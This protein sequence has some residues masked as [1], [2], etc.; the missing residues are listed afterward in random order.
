MNYL[1]QLTLQEREKLVCFGAGDFGQK[2][3]KICQEKGITISYFCDNNPKKWG[4]NLCGV[5]ICSL[6]EI[7]EK[8]EKWVFVL[9]NQKYQDEIEL[10]LEKKGIQEIY[11][12]WWEEEWL[13]TGKFRAWSFL[14]FC[15]NKTKNKI[16]KKNPTGVYLK[17]ANI[18]VTQA[19]T[20]NCKYCAAKVPYLE[21]YDSLSYENFKEQIDLFENFFDSVA[22]IR[23][24]GGEPTLHPKLYEMIQ[25]ASSKNSIGTVITYTNGT[26]LFK[27]EELSKLNNQKIGFSFTDYSVPSAKIDENILILEKYKIGYE[28]RKHDI[29]FDPMA[30]ILEKQEN[31]DDI[32][33]RFAMCIAAGCSSIRDGHFQICGKP[34]QAYQNKSIPM[35]EIDW[36][37]LDV[38]EKSVKQVKC[39][40]RNYLNKKYINTCKYCPGWDATRIQSVPVG[41]QQKGKLSYPPGKKLKHPTLY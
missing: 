35:Q 40:L 6:E 12:S 27:E 33:E 4:T 23:F 16:S 14:N 41:E 19:C 25:Y 20:L 15:G 30:S 26:N 7:L 39:E 29:W 9:S 31:N 22:S 2:F 21:K 34:Q 38:T 36:V 37:D 10:Q 18:T 17:S 3:A 13:Q 28:R 32:E 24:S 1:K 8:K 11:F 5:P